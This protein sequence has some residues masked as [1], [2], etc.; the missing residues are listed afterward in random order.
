MIEYTINA[1]NNSVEFYDEGELFYAQPT[2]PATNKPWSSTSLMRAW[3]EERMAE[4]EAKEAALAAEVAAIEE[5]RLAELA[6]AEEAAAV[7]LAE[8][9]ALAEEALSE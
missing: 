1:L 4:R 3:A 6:A 5:Q 8:A 9:E 7:S 2:D